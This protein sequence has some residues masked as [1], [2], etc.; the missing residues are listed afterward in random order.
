M[1]VEA[2]EAIRRLVVPGNASSHEAAARASF[3]MAPAYPNQRGVEDADGSRVKIVEFL[4]PE[5]VVANLGG[6]TG[7]EVLTEL[8]RPLARY[9]TDSEALLE[10]LLRRE[11]LGSTAV[12]YGV[13][14]PHGTLAGSPGLI[15]SFGRSRSG[16][17]FH[18]IDGKPTRYFFALFA[19]EDRAGLHLKA[20]ARVSHLLRDPALREAIFDAE[21]STDIYRLLAEA[22]G[23]E[24]A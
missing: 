21:D 22:D 11:E 10:A 23:R 7:E 14:I 24:D 13:A 1:V 3:V 12:G 8:C 9:G 2:V 18:A 15:A 6:E 17:D 20:L 19:G 4:R 16:I 5:A